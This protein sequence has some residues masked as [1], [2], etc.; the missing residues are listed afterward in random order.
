MGMFME[1]KMN[2][3]IEIDRLRREYENTPIGLWK[4]R[5]M[6]AWKIDQ[7]MQK[8]SGEER[9]DGVVERFIPDFSYAHKTP[10]PKP[11]FKPKYQP[12]QFAVRP[13][14]VDCWSGYN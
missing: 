3:Q 8:R 6:L 10:F 12:P 7:L 1:W 4:T 9:L 2:Y 5:T 13:A 11:E 14:F